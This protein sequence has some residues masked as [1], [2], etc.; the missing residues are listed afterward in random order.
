MNRIG[1][2][3]YSSSH[4]FAN[5]FLCSVDEERGELLVASL[6][7]IVSIPDGIPL[8]DENN[9]EAKV[10]HTFGGSDD[11][12]TIEIDDVNGTVYAV[13]EKN[14]RSELIALDRKD[15]GTLSP[16]MRYWV[17]TPAVGA[18]VSS[19]KCSYIAIRIVDYSLTKL[20]ASA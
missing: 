8:T 3:V 10:L 13:S 20:A 6:N 17:S 2:N 5:F 12:V 14:S 7:E 11:L 19:L 16:K 4:T 15:D 9:I 1:A 18:M